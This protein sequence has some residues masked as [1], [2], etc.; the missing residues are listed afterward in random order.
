[1]IGS[2]ILWMD[3]CMRREHEVP[4]FVVGYVIVMEKEVEEERMVQNFGLNL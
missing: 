4:I 1:M 3:M 2:V